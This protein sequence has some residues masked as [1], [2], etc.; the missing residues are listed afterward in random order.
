MKILI[1]P[2]SFKHS[3]SAKK[4][5]A[6][7]AEGFQRVFPDA[8]I[9][10]VPVADGGEGTLQALVDATGGRIETVQVHDPLMRTVTSRYGILG[11]G[12]TAVIEMAAASGLELLDDDELDPLAAT[13]FGTGELMHF[14]LDEGCSAMIIGIGGSATND[15]G[16]GMA[17]AL[18][19]RFLDANGREIEHGGGGLNELAEIDLSGLDKRLKE[20][21]ITLAA[22]V[23]NPL[24]GDDG[25]ARVYGP[26]KGA[27][28]EE[29]EIIEANLVRLAELIRKQLAKDIE[30]QPGAGAAGGLGAGLMAFAGAHLH[31][32][33][34]VVK[35]I[36]K[37]EE[38]IRQ[39]DLVVTG[40]GKID[41]QTQFGK[42]PQGVTDLAVKHDKPVIAFAGFLGPEHHELYSKGFGAIFPITDKPMT[43]KE[44][45]QNADALL[46][47]AAERVG[48]AIRIS[49]ELWQSR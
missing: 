6:S 27:D 38:K 7:L 37:L 19:A 47:D 2:D 9:M 23:S 18:G 40:E 31:H 46:A 5:A 20:C 11:D 42:T 8:E 14:A 34:D 16:T 45:L 43:L 32:G 25:A 26:Q 22:D 4:A 44:A 33:F 30:H 10:Q 21:D 49:G 39:A 41:R 48:R 3:L 12:R 24:T 35:E 15:G 13:T 28:N 1:A 29:V 17:R 36:V